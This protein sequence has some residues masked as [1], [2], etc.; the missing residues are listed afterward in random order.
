MQI[1]PAIDLKDGKCVRLKQGRMEDDT[2]FSDDVVATAGRWVASGAKR[3][4][5]VDLDGAFA[6]APR[7]AAI[8]REVCDAFPDLKIQVGGGIRDE[9]IAAGYLEAGVDWVIIGT[10]AVREPEFIKR[11]CNK[12]AD[13]VIVGL[14]ARQGKVALNGWAEDSGVDVIPLAK[15]FEGVGVSAIIYTDID[16]DGMMQGFNWQSTAELADAIDIPVF[17][18]GGVH[19]YEDIDR[20][21]SIAHHGVAGAIV[22][23]AFYEGNMEL[24]TALQRAEQVGANVHS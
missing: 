18:S 4:H 14:D 7:S 9:A 15:S 8:I 12:W 22:G 20:L 17:A 5:I 10:Q 2:V 21:G 11:L 1:I 6:G 24:E 3:L 23:R 13:K 19:D 16:R